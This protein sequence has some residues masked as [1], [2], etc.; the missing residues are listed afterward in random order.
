MLRVFEDYLRPLIGRHLI[1]GKKIVTPLPQDMLTYVLLHLPAADLGKHEFGLTLSRLTTNLRF[2]TGTYTVSRA[3]MCSCRTSIAARPALPALRMS[4]R[5]FSLNPAKSTLQQTDQK[6]F[7]LTGTWTTGLLGG[8]PGSRL[9]SRF[10]APGSRWSGQPPVN[11]GLNKLSA[12]DS[13]LPTVYY[14]Q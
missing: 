11:C 2:G 7:R 9:L 12:Q 8:A 13:H 6:K 14:A 3:A 5:A 1:S 4:T 10:S